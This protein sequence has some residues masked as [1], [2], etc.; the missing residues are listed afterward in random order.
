M[1]LRTLLLPK[2]STVMRDGDNLAL[3]GLKPA[4]WKDTLIGAGLTDWRQDCIEVSALDDSI[5][6]KRKI[7]CSP[8][9]AGTNTGIN[10][11]DP[12][13]VMEME[14]TF[15]ECWACCSNE[16]VW[17]R[18]CLVS[19][20]W[21]QNWFLINKT[22]MFLNNLRITNGFKMDFLYFCFFNYT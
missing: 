14:A 6:S 22:L 17:L 5:D 21:K 1:C 9:I 15:A 18:R 10:L 2:P 16:A 3:G 20:V 4:L 11:S 7:H 8:L 12:I 13:F 19:S